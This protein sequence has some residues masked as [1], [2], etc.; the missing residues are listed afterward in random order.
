MKLK[1]IVFS[2]AT[3]LAALHCPVASAGFFDD[4]ANVRPKARLEA[5]SKVQD[6]ALVDNFYSLS[7]DGKTEGL[8][9]EIPKASGFKVIGL[10]ENTLTIDRIYFKADSMR[11]VY[12]EMRHF[13]KS[14]MDDE[15]GQRYVA[16]ANS[17]GNAIKQYQPAMSG[18]LNKMFNP[19]FEFKGKNTANFLDVENTLIE[20][21]PND[22][23]VSVMLR[24]HQ[25][26]ENFDIRSW[27]YVNILFGSDTVNLIEN[28]IPNK[29][30]ADTFQ[31]IV[32]TAEAPVL[33]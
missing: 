3:V 25:A 15:I 33:K 16:F 26:V 12:G 6:K 29:K 24:A 14:P 2:F 22:R 4:V 18:I 8:V 10:T 23:I 31:R 1:S 27:Q 11:D 32:K 17:R 9:T 13:S 5:Y 19:H 20:F 28:T 30:L 21:T 7:G